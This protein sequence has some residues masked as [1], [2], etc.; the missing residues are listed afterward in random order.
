MVLIGN[1]NTGKTTLLNTLTGANEHTGNWH[2]VTV[3]EKSRF[4]SH[5][6]AVWEVVDLPGVYSLSPFSYDE[7]VACSYV[8]SH[9]DKLFLNAV[10]LHAI[11]KNLYLTL[12]LKILGCKS[13]LLV[14]TFGKSVTGFENVFESVF[15]EK[16]ILF[17]FA[18]KKNLGLLKD[19]I[20]KAK[21]GEKVKQNLAE[22]IFSKG[23]YDF[24][25]RFAKKQNI[26]F[27]YAMK[28]FENDETVLKSNKTLLIEKNKF[29]TE[30]LDKLLKCDGFVLSFQQKNIFEKMKRVGAPKYDNAFIK[31]NKKYLDK[32]LNSKNN[33]KKNQKNGINDKNCEA[34]NV[35]LKK[36]KNIKRNKKLRF[37]VLV[38]KNREIR[39]FFQEIND[40][41]QAKLFFENIVL[42][43]IV[44]EK[45]KFIA[46][47]FSVLQK[48][49]DRQMSFAKHGKKKE[50]L[51][52]GQREHASERKEK[53]SKKLGHGQGGYGEE[54]LDR[55]LLNRFLA[56]PI[57]L[58]VMLFVFYIT[59]FSVG[60]FLSDGLSFVIQTLLGGMLIDFL[61]SFCSVGWVVGLVEVALVDGVGSLV[62]FLPQIVFLFLFLAI[63]EDSGYLSRIAFCLE[64]V[65][66]KVGLSGKSVYTLLMGFGCSASAVLTA[67]NMENKASKI[68]TAI[69]TPYMSCSAKLPIYAV[70]GGAFFGAG[71][72]LII[73]L[74]YLL[75]VMVALAV[76]MLF[77]RLGLKN[78]EEVFILEFPP[79]RLSRP[80]HI[81]KI[82]WTSLK[83]FLIKITTIFVSMS[84]IVW[85]L[86]SFSFEFAYVVESG[87]KSMLEVMGE[88][89][90][91]VFA[92]LGFNN[93]GAVSALLAGVVAKEI[94]V[95]SIAIFNGIKENSSVSEVGD[96]LKDSAS[97][98]HFSAASALSYMSFCLLYCPCLATMA[99]LKKEIGLKWTL[100]AILVQLLVAYGVSFVIFN[101]YNVFTAL[102]LAT[103][104]LLALALFLIVSSVV[105][106]FRKICFGRIC[107]CS[108]N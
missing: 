80:S 100:I 108:K 26:D 43:M 59:F 107:G 2:G 85:T 81:L 18:D 61:S 42:D 15:G 11:C 73:F 27:F 45:Q 49:I 91:P 21:H 33:N 95:S 104:L 30:N 102:G 12:D 5:N 58:T 16:P 9:A 10:D 46:E 36:I 101:L 28:V 50:K 56:I 13:I 89:F 88:F 78:R 17:D 60:A 32:Y 94:V 38:G 41:K 79:Y 65:F 24:L 35:S 71:N 1:A 67:R 37:S 68:K 69:L 105:F 98:V 14:N 25:S 44:F 63:L 106:F 22:K 8:L 103:T 20:V 6:N 70:L 66:K 23:L 87:G 74:L 34:N 57:F 90:A 40:K 86:S 93:W 31:I 55:I 39:N 51:A 92:P 54:F 7:K 53:K 77:D 47:N 99:V 97:A 62:C 3:E 19:E 48:E 84:V 52:S 76:S 75:G 4:F 72:V 82:V 83:M 29:L 64:D 96:S